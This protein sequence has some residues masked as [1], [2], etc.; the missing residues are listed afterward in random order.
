MPDLIGLDK[1]GKDAVDEAAKDLASLV[2]QID[3][4]LTKTIDYLALKLQG[5]LVGRTITITIK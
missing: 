4:E 1:A 2:A 3:P 5:L